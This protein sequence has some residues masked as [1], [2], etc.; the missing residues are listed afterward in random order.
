MEEEVFEEEKEEDMVQSKLGDVLE[1]L[2]DDGNTQTQKR[3]EPSSTGYG[4]GCTTQAPRFKFPRM[5][6]WVLIIY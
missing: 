2:K 3:S 4:S 5:Q 1:P 6:I